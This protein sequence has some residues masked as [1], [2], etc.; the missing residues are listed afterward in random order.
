[1]ARMG[2]PAPTCARSC[3]GVQRRLRSGRRG[4][5]ADARA[6][7]EFAPRRLARREPRVDEWE[8]GDRASMQHDLVVHPDGSIYSVDTNQDQLYRLDP[9][10]RRR[11]HGW[12]IPPGDLPLGGVFGATERLQPPNA[13]AH[14]GPHSLQVAPDG[15]IWIT[16]ALGNQIARFDPATRAVDDAR[17]RGGLLPAHAALRC[18]RTRLVHARRVESHRHVRS[19]DRRAA[20]H[21]PAGARLA[22]AVALRAMPS[23]SGSA[24]TSTSAAPRRERRRRQ[25]AGAVRHRHRA[26]RR[27]LV[28]PAQRAPHRSRRSRHASRSR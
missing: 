27:R 12:T 10:A 5:G 17:A 26:R 8:L 24:A 19:R 18:A 22:Q 23:S 13:N 9:R 7:P 25:P 16:L 28:Q 21:P 4:G 15:S 14:V 3:R 20:R 6:P 2:G 11:A 1:M